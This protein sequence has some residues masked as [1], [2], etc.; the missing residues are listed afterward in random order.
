MRDGPWAS[1]RGAGG[2]S[3]AD[4]PEPPCC[5]RRPSE[6][7]TVW[8]IQTVG[9]DVRPVGETTQHLT[10][11]A[12]AAAAAPAPRASAR[13]DRAGDGPRSARGLSLIHISEPTR[14]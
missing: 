3:G 14:L 2:G 10:A 12:Q 1:L 7:T 6:I 8:K 13:W 5:R 9:G 11:A 4:G